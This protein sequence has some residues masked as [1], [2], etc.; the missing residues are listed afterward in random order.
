MPTVKKLEP[1]TGHDP[2]HTLPRGPAVPEEA[3]G[4][5]S[6]SEKGPWENHLRLEG[7][8]GEFRDDAVSHPQ[9]EERD[10]N[11]GTNGDAKE[12]EA[13]LREVKAVGV[14]EDERE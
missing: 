6:R 7:R 12:D 9:Q 3:K 1:M 8:F 2:V 10:G 13:L 14:A 4:Q 5:G 11:E